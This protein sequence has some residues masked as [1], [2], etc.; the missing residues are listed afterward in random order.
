ML[1]PPKKRELDRS[2]LV[3]LER[4]VPPD[5]FY[6]HLDLSF[7]RDWGKD[8][9]AAAGRPS[10]D[11]VIFFRFRLIM[12]FEGMRSERQGVEHAALNLA[13]CWYLGYH[14][15]ELLPDRS[16]LIKIRQR[17]GLETFRSFFKHIV[18]LCQDAGLIWGKE[19]LADATKVQANS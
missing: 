3:S 6:R 12:F 17:V 7:V 1:G 9:Y 11:P 8:R 13:Q 19:V 2:V 10:I 15:D 18:D 5:H 4:L 14:L 16:S